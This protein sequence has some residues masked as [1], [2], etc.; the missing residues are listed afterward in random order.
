MIETRYS[1]LSESVRNDVI[2]L[3]RLRESEVVLEPFDGPDD[4]DAPHTLHLVP[5]D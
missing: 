3:V 5:T 2:N 4:A 1:R